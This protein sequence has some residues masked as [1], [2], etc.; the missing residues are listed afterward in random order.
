MGLEGR[1]CLNSLAEQCEKGGSDTFEGNQFGFEE[2]KGCSVHSTGSLGT[3]AGS[4]QVFG[5]NHF[6]CP[7]SI[8]PSLASVCAK[9]TLEGPV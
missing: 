9:R 4:Q 8:L 7:G 5:P 2:G 6:V 1:K 3:P